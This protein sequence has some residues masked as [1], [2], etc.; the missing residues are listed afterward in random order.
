[1]PN[2]KPEGA[3]YYNA[4]LNYLFIPSDNLGSGESMF[5]LNY[6]VVWHFIG[7]V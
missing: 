5:L 3:I 4:E 6:G 7:H 2:S 1:M